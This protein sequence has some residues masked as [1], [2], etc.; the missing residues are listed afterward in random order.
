MEIP[1]ND[2]LQARTTWD[3]PT[4][5][6]SLG[7]D[8]SLTRVAAKIEIEKGVFQKGYEEDGMKSVYEVVEPAW[9]LFAA[10]IAAYIAASVTGKPDVADI[11]TAILSESLRTLDEALKPESDS[12]PKEK[13]N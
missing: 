2:G 12:L 10:S 11:V 1:P 3:V 6:F 13:E 9:A 8:A 4:Q 7:F 5:S